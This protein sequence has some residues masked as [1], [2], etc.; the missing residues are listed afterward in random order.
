MRARLI[1]ALIGTVLCSAAQ[2]DSNPVKLCTN[3]GHPP[4]SK[5]YPDCERALKAIDEEVKREYERDK[6]EQS[7]KNRFDQV[8]RGLNWRAAYRKCINTAYVSQSGTFDSHHVEIVVACNYIRDIWVPI[9]TNYRF[10]RGGIGYYT[11][12]AECAG[13]VSETMNM[14]VNDVRTDVEINNMLMNDLKRF[15]FNQVVRP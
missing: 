8:P 2:A 12:Q 5:D 13:Y 10:N 11:A 15:G 6:Q 4:G 1:F 3:V 9:C 7:E 14:I